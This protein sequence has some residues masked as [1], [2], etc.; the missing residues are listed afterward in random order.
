MESN[1]SK[2]G[3]GLSTTSSVES[4]LSTMSFAEAPEST[5]AMSSANESRPL[6]ASLVSN[7]E[8]EVGQVA[9]GRLSTRSSVESSLST[10]KCGLSMTNPMEGGLLTVSSVESDLSTVSSTGTLSMTRMDS[11]QSSPMTGPSEDNPHTS[12]SIAT[13]GLGSSAH[14]SDPLHSST[15]EPMAPTVSLSR[16]RLYR[17]RHVFFVL[18]ALMQEPLVQS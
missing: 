17:H 11:T 7:L 2:I 8:S 14:D 5:L 6:T 18:L 10:P 3:S 12:G 1:L 4:C 13:P 15:N 16:P 9:E